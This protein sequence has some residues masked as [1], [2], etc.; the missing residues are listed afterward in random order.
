MSL[1]KLYATATLVFLVAVNHQ[2]FSQSRS[3]RLHNTSSLTLKDKAICI[4]RASLLHADEGKFPLIINFKGDTIASQLDDI[5]GD[6]KWDEL[7]FVI[8]MA[9]KQKVNLTLNWINYVPKFTKRTSV[10]F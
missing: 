7:F 8:D 5:D 9:P 10:R 4:K 6:M 2:V 1:F 3:I